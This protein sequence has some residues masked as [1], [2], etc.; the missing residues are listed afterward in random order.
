MK[1]DQVLEALQTALGESLLD[2]HVVER[3]VAGGDD[4]TTYPDLWVKVDRSAL[5]DATAALLAA[6]VPHLTVISGDDLGETLLLNYH[7]TVGWGTH[8][9]ELCV[10]VQIGVPKSDFRVP[11]ITDLVPGA[12]T[13]EREKHEFYGVVFDG[14]PDDRNLFLP[15]GMTIH[16]WRRDEESQ[17]ETDTMVERLVKWET[18]DA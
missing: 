15:E 4:R 13:S 14:I 12:L 6:F 2:A 1:T 3:I 7:F 5:R 10:T 9:G 11:T 16:P 8:F 17:R 18:K